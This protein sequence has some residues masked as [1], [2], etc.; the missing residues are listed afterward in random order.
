MERATGRLRETGWG[1]QSSL[2]KARALSGEST[3][4][5]QA[6]E[7]LILASA[8]SVVV[9]GQLGTRST[10]FSWSHGADGQGSR[11]LL[12]QPDLGSCWLGQA[13]GLPV[14]DAV[15]TAELHS[16]QGLV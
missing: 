13:C 14:S 7:W 2:C 3:R 11:A 15:S 10:C 9:A 12:H 5:N 8:A 1:R 6:Q 16:G 4:G